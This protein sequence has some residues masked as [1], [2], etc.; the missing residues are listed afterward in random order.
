MTATKT[1]SSYSMPVDV[2]PIDDEPPADL[3][4]TP[5]DPTADL[6]AAAQAAGFTRRIQQLADTVRPKP[7]GS[8]SHDAPPPLAE[9]SAE[10]LAEPVDVATRPAA[11]EQRSRTKASGP[12]KASW[13]FGNWKL[14]NSPLSDEPPPCADA[15]REQSTNGV[16]GHDDLEVF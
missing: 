8:A 16:V 5:R 4:L 9:A 6:L 15:M 14:K 12:N 11:P 2:T 1:L 10:A 7:S 3:R 13:L